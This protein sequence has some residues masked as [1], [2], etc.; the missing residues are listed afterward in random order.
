M[1]SSVI[2]E[3]P[4]QVGGRKDSARF[5]SANPIPIGAK[6][7]LETSTS[8]AAILRFHSDAARAPESAA[9]TAKRT[10]AI[11]GATRSAA[12]FRSQSGARRATIQAA[13][14]PIS[15]AERLSRTGKRPPEPTRTN[16]G[17]S[18]AI[19]GAKI[20]AV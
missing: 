5:V 6:T 3:D 15:A 2:S 20:A 10:P 14:A 11:A 18:L 13:I 16:Q 17:R 8:P 1:P 4:S 7:G 9:R 12:G 19:S